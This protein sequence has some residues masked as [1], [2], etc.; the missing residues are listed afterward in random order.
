MVNIF[1]VCLNMIIVY[2]IWLLGLMTYN[3]CIN[4]IWCSI[5]INIKF[6]IKSK[7]RHTFHITECDGIQGRQIQN[8]LLTCMSYRLIFMF[9]E[10][11]DNKSNNHFIKS[12]MRSVWMLHVTM[13]FRKCFIGVNVYVRMFLNDISIKTNGIYKILNIFL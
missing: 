2:G 4:G 9:N 13:V 3:V 8:A 5:C 10:Y 7:S 6:I 1:A 12:I 11:K